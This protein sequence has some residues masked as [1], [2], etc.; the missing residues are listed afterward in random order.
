MISRKLINVTKKEMPQKC[1]APHVMLTA[2]HTY[3]RT[4][5]RLAIIVESSVKVN[6]NHHI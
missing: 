3:V 2:L 6:F 4:V 5:K 1:S